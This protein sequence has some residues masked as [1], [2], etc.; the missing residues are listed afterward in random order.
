MRYVLLIGGSLWIGVIAA[1]PGYFPPLATDEWATTDPAT[2]GYCPAAVDSLYAFLEARNS[3]AFL[4][5]EDGRIVLERYF[6]DFEVTTPHVWN[7]AG[8]TVTALA[9]GIAQREGLLDLDDPASD[10]LGVGWTSCDSTA[11]AAITIRHLLA[12]SSGLD[13]DVPDIYCTLPE[14]LTCLTEPGQRWAYHNGA[15]T[16]LTYILEAASGQALNPFINQRIRQP[17]GMNGGYFGAGY[18]R[19]FG[20]TAR[21]M[22][23]FGLLALNGGDWADTPVLDDSTYFREMTTPSQ[24]L[25]P[26]YG[27]LWWLNGQANF[28]LPGVPFVIDGPLVPTAPATLLAAIG[29]NG[30]LLL[31]DPD[32]QRIIIRMGN[33]PGYGSGV[34]GVQLTTELW[35]YVAALSCSTNTTNPSQALTIELTPQPASTYLSVRAAMAELRQASLFSAR[36]QCLVDRSIARPTE[37]IDLALTEVPPGLYWLRIITT[38]GQLLWRSVVVQR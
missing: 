7:S 25:N 19:V 32:R 18:N 10:Y 5:V 6:G 26:A 17:T 14:C 34:V 23:R 13:D 33:D 37:R 21:S 20:S 1:Q 38:E 2:L 16:Q 9:V 36:G 3:A 8:K 31:V 24:S 22:A 29:K 11:E 30:Q 28:R 12:Q 27:Y 35:S 4:L 15:Y